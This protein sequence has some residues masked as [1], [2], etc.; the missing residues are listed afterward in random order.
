M[1]SRSTIKV[2]QTWCKYI[3]HDKAKSNWNNPAGN[4]TD[5]FITFL[6]NYAYHLNDTRAAKSKQT[7]LTEETSGWGTMDGWQWWTLEG[8]WSRNHLQQIKLSYNTFHILQDTTLSHWS[9]TFSVCNWKYVYLIQF[10]MYSINFL[11]VLYSCKINH[12]QIWPKF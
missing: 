1:L 8:L 10:S 12:Y 5:L 9:E 4:F 11:V 3:Y 7:W 6:G 2:H